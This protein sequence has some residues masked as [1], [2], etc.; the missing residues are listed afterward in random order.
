MVLLIESGRTG[1]KFQFN[2]EIIWDVGWLLKKKSKYQRFQ[3]ERS[4]FFPLLNSSEVGDQGWSTPL[5]SQE[6]GSF[7]LIP[8][9]IG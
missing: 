7:D 9:S 8:P 4:I 2:F 5:G 6:P 1:F 3:Q